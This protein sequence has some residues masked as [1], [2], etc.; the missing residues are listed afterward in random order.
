M[1]RLERNPEQTT[2]RQFHARRLFVCVCLE[3]ELENKK[4]RQ[5]FLFCV[6]A[7]KAFLKEGK[8]L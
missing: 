1:S 2:T 6:R 8:N 4:K 7:N 5:K 3:K